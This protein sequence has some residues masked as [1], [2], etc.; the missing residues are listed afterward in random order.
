MEYN[1]DRYPRTMVREE[2]SGWKTSSI[3]WTTIV[4]VTVSSIM[5]A[6][7]QLIWKRWKSSCSKR[8]SNP[9]DN[10]GDTFNQNPPADRTEQPDA[11][12]D[13]KSKA[14]RQLSELMSFNGS[15][16]ERTESVFEL[17]RKCYA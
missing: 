1:E 3:V 15:K 12:A 16:S 17:V 7:Y 10:V 11:S 8:K 13:A 4:V 6:I 14:C 9:Q 5:V 2:K